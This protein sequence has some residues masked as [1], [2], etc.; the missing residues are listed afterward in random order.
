M[1][2]PLVGVH[3]Q[4]GVVVFLFLKNLTFPKLSCAFLTFLIAFEETLVPITSELLFKIEILKKRNKNPLCIESILLKC[5]VLTF[6]YERLGKERMFM[7]NFQKKYASP[8]LRTSMRK[9]S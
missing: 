7:S 8:G 6:K 4:M 9:F 3:A 1:L 5:C 2:H